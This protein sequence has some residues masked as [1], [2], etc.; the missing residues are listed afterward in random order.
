MTAI[1]PTLPPSAAQADRRRRFGADELVDVHCHLLP[2]LDDGPATMADAVALC[3]AMVDDGITTAVATP[4][5]LGK[6]GL[7]NS[8]AVVR[9]AVAELNGVL[10]AE[11]VPLRVVAGGD[12]RVDDQLADLLAGGQVLTLGDGGAFLLIELPHESIVDLSGLTAALVAAGVTPILSHPERN[13]PLARRSDPMLPWLDAGQLLQVTAGSLVGRFG[14]DAER[15]GWR[16]VEAGQVAMLATDA[17]H[18]ADRPPA[19]T[20]AVDAVAKRLGHAVARRLCVENP[21]KVLAG[22]RGGLAPSSRRRPAVAVQ[23][24]PRRRWWG[25]FA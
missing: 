23:R 6:F 10:A 18:A 3:R 22:D 5:Q 4:H 16:M 13:A 14:P 12:V 25:W 11:A 7:A 20:A 24:P 19:M 1:V 2:G 21:A 9:A 15:A 8:P 17:H